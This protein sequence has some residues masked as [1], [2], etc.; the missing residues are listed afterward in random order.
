MA[1]EM[2]DAEFELV[3]ELIFVIGLTS[4][5]FVYAVVCDG[6]AKDLM[7]KCKRVR[8]EIERERTR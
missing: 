2:S 1:T 3:I 7:R 5:S 6:W 4:L 8:K